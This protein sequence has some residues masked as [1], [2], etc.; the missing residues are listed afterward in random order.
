MVG[1]MIRRSVRR[2]FRN[3]YWIPP[4]ATPAPPVI[5]VPNHHGWH[6]GYLMYHL[7]TTLGLRSVDWITEFDAFPLFAKIGGMPFPVATSARRI[8]T[9]KRTIRLMKKENRSLVLFAEAELHA[10][11]ELLPFGKALETVAKAVPNAAILPIAIRYEMGIHE[12]PEAFLQI[13]EPIQ[14]GGEFL[15]RTRRA[16]ADLLKKPT[17][18]EWQI[19]VKGTPD[20]NERWDMRRLPRKMR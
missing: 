11:P 14:R 19:L 12:R 20:V 17:P 1:G 15:E 16:V 5:L 3:V 10:A 2:S 7:V 13:G 9:V 4:L 8:A 6:D 18:A